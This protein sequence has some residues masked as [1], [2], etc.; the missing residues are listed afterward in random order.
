LLPAGF[1][2]SQINIMKKFICFCIVVCTIQFATAQKTVFYDNFNDNYNKWTTY[3]NG[4]ISYVIYNG[5]YV[6]DVNDSNTY[7]IFVPVAF[8]TGKDFSISASTVHTSGDNNHGYGLYFGGSDVNNYY[9][10]YLTSGGYY[11][12]GK[13]I[14]GGGSD[15]IP[16]TTSTVVKTG[17]YVENKIKI[18]RQGGSWKI[19]IN[20]Q[21]INTIAAMPLMG[22][23]VG[24][25]LSVSQRVE[26]DDLTVT[27]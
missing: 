17:N 12:L 6:I 9:Y 25:T 10:L 1:I 14:A 26:F 7:N 11:K 2:H 19:F 22:N 5:K 8:D 24:F 27:Q 20:D 4:G 23:K 3:T 21:L 16:W 15:I 13:S 18:S